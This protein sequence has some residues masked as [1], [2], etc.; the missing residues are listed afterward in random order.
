MG[1]PIDQSEFWDERASAWARNADAMEGFARQ[2][3]DLA[4]DSL[5]PTPGQHL[6]DVGCGPGLTTIEL[7]RRV[8]PSGTATGVDVSGKMIETAMARARAVDVRNVEFV[9]DDPG[10]HPIG[11]FDG[12]YSRFGVMFFDEP[13][14][15]FRNMARSVRP[16]GR[17]VA[18]VWAELDS[19]PWMFVPTLFGAGPLDAEPMLPGP[20]EPGP[21]S[22]ADPVL[23]TSLL[24][25]CGFC[26]VEVARHEQAWTF[27]ARTA[28]ESIA[29]LLSVGALAEAWASADDGTRAAAVEAV[30]S[31][32][33]DYREAD[34]WRL[35]ATALTISAYVRS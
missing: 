35:P 9:V 23:T 25:T 28:D 17:L 27:D 24:E 8:A 14:T 18:V 10:A 26:D 5:D 34:G 30:R 16:G 6:A 2:F 4:M 32:C 19:N 12:I 11:S 22:L 7:D 29:Q 3:G 15:A 1:Q 20:H 33:E 13:T 21:F 31:A